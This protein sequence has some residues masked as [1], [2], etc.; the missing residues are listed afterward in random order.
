MEGADED[1]GEVLAVEDED[2]D[3]EGED[4]Q[5]GG[6]GS[7]PLMAVAVAVAE[8]RGGGVLHRP[9]SDRRLSDRRRLN[10]SPAL[11]I[12]SMRRMLAA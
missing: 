2:E 4:Q 12:H 8:R 1:A 6:K 5:V 7:P 3:D 11:L 9:M 10:G